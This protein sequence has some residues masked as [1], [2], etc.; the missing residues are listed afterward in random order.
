MAT[1]S[2]RPEASSA[3]RVVHGRRQTAKISAALAMRSQ[4]T[5]SGWTSANRRTAKAGPR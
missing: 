1:T 2:R 4:A 5:P 3:A